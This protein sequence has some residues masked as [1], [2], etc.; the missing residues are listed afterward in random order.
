MKPSK[1]ILLVL[2]SIV[3]SSLL[4]KTPV[5]AAG[6]TA[7]T[8][9]A[10]TPPVFNLTVNSGVA[11]NEQI[12]LNNLGSSA[13]SVVVALKDFSQDP[14][15][16]QVLLENL[17]TE[18]TYSLSSMIKLGS[19]AVVVPA[20]SS[21]LVPFTVNV[22]NTTTTG[23]RYAAI[24]FTTLAGG[25]TGSQTQTT[26][27]SLVYVDVTG[28]G[29]TV[30][31]INIDSLTVN[32]NLVPGKIKIQGSISN[33]GNINE[34]VLGSITV[35]DDSGNFVTVLHIPAF[36][37]LPSGKRTIT[38]TFDNGSLSGNYNVTMTLY[39]KGLKVEKSGTFFVL[40]VNKILIGIGILLLVLINVIYFTRR[41]RTK[42]TTVVA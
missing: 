11:D 21:V 4:V 29:N 42:K 13:E 18:K 19:N 17:G 6:T 12:K 37:L 28:A 31:K 32:G 27:T 9:L 22:P 10:L 23:A 36:N 35:K 33:A 1:I 26:L 8:T 2:V 38:D 5:Y 15:T 24:T 16:G 40:P 34:S 3:A 39:Y 41:F 7:T 30:D 25:N 14:N 20:H